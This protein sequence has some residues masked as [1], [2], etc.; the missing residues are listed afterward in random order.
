[1]KI[2]EVSADFYGDFDYE[3][4]TTHHNFFAVDNDVKNSRTVFIFATLL[5]IWSNLV[6]SYNGKFYRFFFFGKKCVTKLSYHTMHSLKYIATVNYT[7]KN[8]HDTSVSEPNHKNSAKL[9]YNNKFSHRERNAFN[10]ANCEAPITSI[11]R[12]T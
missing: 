12:T 4:L 3:L 8:L 2:K 6:E 5:S 9:F 1:M 7:C 11:A 10:G